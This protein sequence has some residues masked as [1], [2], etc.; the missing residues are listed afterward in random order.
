MSLPGCIPVFLEVKA[1]NAAN[2][3]YF[4]NWQELEPEE[5]AFLIAHYISVQ[6]VENNVKDAENRAVKAQQH[7]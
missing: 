6:L 2:Y 4:G 5:Q 1:C 7:K 3:Q